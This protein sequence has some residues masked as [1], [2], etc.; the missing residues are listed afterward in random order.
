ML[1]PRIYQN[2][3]K[4]LKPKKALILY[5]SRQIGKTTLLETYLAN[6]DLKYKLD[7]GDN[8]RIQHIFSSKDFDL[9]KE[10][11]QGYELI[12][13]D[14]AQKIPGVGEGIKIIVDQIDDIRIIATGSSSFEL[15]GQIDEPLTGRKTTLILYPISQLELKELHNDYELKQRQEE[16]LIFGGYPEVVTARTRNEKISLIEEV[17][18]SYLLKDILQLEILTDHQ[19]KSGDVRDVL[20]IRVLQKWEITI[21]EN[22]SIAWRLNSAWVLSLR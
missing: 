16:F 22:R 14:E 20:A 1:I 19:G 12:A 4:Y 11:A 6:S 13:I 7:S 17:A 5:G 3:S 9:I 8:I 2:L 10:Y 21:N 18:Q 15:A